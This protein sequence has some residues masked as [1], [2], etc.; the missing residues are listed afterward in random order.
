[1][2]A[3]DELA[4]QMSVLFARWPDMVQP[5][6]AIPGASRERLEK[7][8]PPGGINA[9]DNGSADIAIAYFTG[10]FNLE[11]SVYLWE[12]ESAISRGEAAAADVAKNELDWYIR[13]AN[14]SAGLLETVQA[15]PPL[16]VPFFVFGL[17][18]DPDTDYYAYSPAGSEGIVLYDRAPNPPGPQDPLFFYQPAGKAVLQVADPALP[19]QAVHTWQPIPG[20]AGIVLI[21]SGVVAGLAVAELI[22][23]YLAGQIS[24][25]AVLSVLLLLGL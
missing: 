4:G 5:E 7:G 8:Q 22:G 1:L 25:E 23:A 17:P 3:A 14:A 10:P 13:A 19:P 12:V 18:G 6:Y 21:G 9:K 15:G 20:I 2:I 16:A 11:E 24:W